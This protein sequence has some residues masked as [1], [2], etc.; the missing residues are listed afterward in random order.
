MNYLESR[1]WSRSR[2]ENAWRKVS[3][4]VM[5]ALVLLVRGMVGAEA[6]EGKSGL[7]IGY[8]TDT[9]MPNAPEGET[10]TQFEPWVLELVKKSIFG[11]A[12]AKLESY[13][14]FEATLRLKKFNWDVFPMYAYDFVRLEKHCNLEAILVPS[15]ESG[16]L[17]EYAIY[18]PENSRIT[19]VAHLNQK[20]VLFEINGRGELPY[21]W[22]DNLIRRKTGQSSKAITVTKSVSTALLA[23]LPVY[24]QED[25]IDAC[26]ISKAGMQEIMLGNPQVG[27]F[28]RHLEGAPAMLT[29]VIA[30]RRDLS[31]EQRQ[32][33]I[34][35]S[36]AMGKGEKRSNQSTLHFLP[37][38]PEYLE[39]LKREFMEHDTNSQNEPS[40]SE[41]SVKSFIPPKNLIDA[42]AAAASGTAVPRT[43]SASNKPPF[44]YPF[45]IPGS[46][47]P[48]A[49]PASNR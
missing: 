2:V 24:F 39:Q 17:A 26:V 5:V 49:Q 36:L 34:A 41:Q 45:R 29:H 14:D 10:R 9:L 18:V 48:A 28:L 30:C 43:N 22:F 32:N 20:H 12:E 3:R 7:R 1:N 35:T 42:R 19:D 25:N 46:K 21:Y 8:F 31:N 16:P 13:A 38:K 27:R 33:I 4:G 47:E 40:Q 23:A 11:A 44:V 15:W 37:F 6:A